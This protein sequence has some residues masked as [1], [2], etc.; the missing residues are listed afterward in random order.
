MPNPLAFLQT[1]W[2]PSGKRF[3]SSIEYE[4]YRPL[5]TELLPLSPQQDREPSL[6]NTFIRSFVCT[7]SVTMLSCIPSLNNGGC[8]GAHFKGSCLD[9]DIG[10][11]IINSRHLPHNTG[12]QRKIGLDVTNSPPCGRQNRWKHFCRSCLLQNRTTRKSQAPDRSETRAERPP[13]QFR[14]TNDKKTRKS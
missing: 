5:T 2:G 6:Y 8:G 9:N 10:G 1:I 12:Q 11:D 13:H 7:I 4:L 3:T 14:A